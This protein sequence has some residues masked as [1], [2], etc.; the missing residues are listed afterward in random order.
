MFPLRGF[1]QPPLGP[2][3]GVRV[4]KDLDA[5][6]R[7]DHR[8]DVPAFQTTL[9]SVLMRLLSHHRPAQART[10]ETIE[11]AWETSAWIAS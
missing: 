7:E 3:P 10:V 11:A 8:S 9:A 2:H 5:G 1:H 4:Q 6:V